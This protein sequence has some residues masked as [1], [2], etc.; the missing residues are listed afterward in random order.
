LRP[1]LRH[2]RLRIDSSGI[3][4]MQ[5]ILNHASEIGSFIGGLLAGGAGGSLITVKIFRRNAVSGGTITD[6]SRARA[7]GDI[8]GRDKRTL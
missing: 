3:Y 8:V 6:Q 4:N 5:W 1:R 2:L 7:G